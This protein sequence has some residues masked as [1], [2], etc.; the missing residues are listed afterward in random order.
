[1]LEKVCAIDLRDPRT[2]TGTAFRTAIADVV[3]E[4]VRLDEGEVSSYLLVCDRSVGQYLYDVVLDA[5][6]E[7][8]LDPQGG[9]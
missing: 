7:F 1:L 2:P 8:W 3:V 6:S 4:V 5:G 9:G